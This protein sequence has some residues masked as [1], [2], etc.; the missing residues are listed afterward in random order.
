MFLNSCSESNVVDMIKEGVMICAGV[1]GAEAG[2]QHT[3]RQM[4]W[5]PRPPGFD[6]EETEDTE[7][8]SHRDTENLMCLCVLCGCL[9]SVSS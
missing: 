7:R 2:R 8:V 5:C 1:G 6:T 3:K 9:C 4:P